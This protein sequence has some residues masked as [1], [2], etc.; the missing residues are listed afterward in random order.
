LALLKG[1]HQKVAAKAQTKQEEDRRQQ[2][3]SQTKDKK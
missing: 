3:Q 2:A 1:L